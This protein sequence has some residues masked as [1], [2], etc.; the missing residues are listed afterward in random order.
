MLL[1]CYAF[2]ILNGLGCYLTLYPALLSGFLLLP[3]EGCFAF[4]LL[5]DSTVYHQVWLCHALKSQLTCLVFP[6]QADAAKVV[7][8]ILHH[9]ALVGVFP[10][11]LYIRNTGFRH[12]LIHTLLAL[13]GYLYATAGEG[14]H[15]V[16][17]YPEHINHVAGGHYRRFGVLIFR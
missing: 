14:A 8:I 11:P 16:A 9:K 6:V 4:G 12:N 13:H 15:V 7:W 1:W 10:T 2:G 3:D 17:L 5:L